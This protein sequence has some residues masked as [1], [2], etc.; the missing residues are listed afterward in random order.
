VLDANRSGHND[1]AGCQP[2]LEGT[3]LGGGVGS[4]SIALNPSGP[5]PPSIYRHPLSSS[6]SIRLILPLF[7]KRSSLKARPQPVFPLEVRSQSTVGI[8][9][10]LMLDLSNLFSDGF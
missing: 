6:T 10:H 8:E 3:A 2:G 9:S 5:S 1:A 7:L 4:P